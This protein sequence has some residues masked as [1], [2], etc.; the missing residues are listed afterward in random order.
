MTSAQTYVA[1]GIR[2]TTVFP[3][4]D[5]PLADGP[6]DVTIRSGRVTDS[7]VE[8]VMAGERSFENPG[9]KFRFSP[10]GM[11]AKWDRVGKVLVRDGKEVI[12]EREPGVTL[13]DLSPFL[14]GPVLAAVLHQ[15]GYFVLHASCVSING[16]AA[17]FVGPK[18][19]GKSTIAALLKARGHLLVSDDIVPLS[20]GSETI[21]IEPGF[22][23]IKLYD[24][25]IEAIGGDPTDYP[26]IHRFAS[27][28]SFQTTDLWDGDPI[29]LR[30]IYLLNESSEFHITELTGI[31]AFIE[32]MKNAHLGRFL[33][34]TESQST[35]FQSCREITK[36]VPVFRLD[37]PSSFAE[38]PRIL[39]GLE[40]HISEIVLDDSRTGKRLPTLSSLEVP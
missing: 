25:S 24:D 5:L 2:L 3:L 37:R 35:Y 18:G 4:D 1:Y 30:S 29:P 39:G 33:E 23:R 17:L 8:T 36:T 38:M 15:R 9:A 7:M 10:R 6:T 34:E 32:I 19:S 13:E 31:N 16:A 11:Y 27:K 21:L 20:V 28:R 26:T 22:P 12:V 14:T 40:H